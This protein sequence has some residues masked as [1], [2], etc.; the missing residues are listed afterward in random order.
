M[1]SL[2]TS[3]TRSF[4]HIPHLLPQ[5]DFVFHTLN[6]CDLLFTAYLFSP[7][8]NFGKAMGGFASDPQFA[9]FAPSFI[10]LK[11]VFIE[12]PRGLLK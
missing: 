9:V 7:R 1:P 4:I 10:Q 12:F 3:L 6:E 5:Q 8:R 11:K 2:M